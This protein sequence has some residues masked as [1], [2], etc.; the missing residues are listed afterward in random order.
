[1]FISAEKCKGK[2]DAG[3]G[4]EPKKSPVRLPFESPNHICVV[5][6]SLHPEDRYTVSDIAWEVGFENDLHISTIV[7][8][9]KDVEL[10]LLSVS[11]LLD[12]IR[13]EGI[14]V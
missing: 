1:M 6:P 8:T 4:R 10:G 13:F 12:A 14:A 3:N 2:V 11:P 7:A 5:L 9:E